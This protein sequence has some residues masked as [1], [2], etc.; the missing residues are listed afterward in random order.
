MAINVRRFFR[1]IFE[2]IVKIFSKPEAPPSTG[3]EVVDPGPGIEYVELNICKV[4]GLVSGKYCAATET[5]TYEMGKEPVRV[6]QVCK[7]LWPEKAA[8]PLYVFVAELLVANGNK[9]TFLELCR[10]SGVHG[11]RFFALQS[12]SKPKRIEPFLQAECDG[13]PVTYVQPDTKTV[14]PVFDMEKPNPA[15]R[16]RLRE[17]LALLKE[18]DLEAV[19][20][21]HDFCSYKGDKTTKFSYP[22]LCSLQTMSKDEDWASILPKA[23]Q[24]LMVKS[25]GGIYGDTALPGPENSRLYWHKKWAKMVMGE[26][27]ASGVT[28]RIEPVNEFGGL[29]WVDEGRPDVPISWYEKLTNALIGFGAKK[30][31][32][33]HSGW[34][35]ACLPMGGTYCLHN[36]VRPEDIPS[37]VKYMLSGDG[38]TK[39]RSTTDIDI[40]GRKG[41]SVDDGRK[42]ARIIKA[43][44]MGGYDHMPKILNK[45]NDNLVNVDFMQ[46]DVLNAMTEESLK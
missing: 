35:E 3:G 45:L 38:G 4:S 10:L 46:Y 25:D 39:G 22:F 7:R 15:Y 23:A 21:I 28:Y 36:I 27:K 14:W 33:I 20:S 2:W 26:L 34:P 12:W 44:G 37:G 11:I 1:T 19:V 31:E 41:L 32:M 9:R 16:T 43:R 5:R 30:N 8:F 6:C 42:I 29:A 13:V 18:Y 17:I 40:K 24:A